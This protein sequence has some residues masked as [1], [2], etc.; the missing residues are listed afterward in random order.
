MEAE[1]VVPGGLDAQTSLERVQEVI[2][3]LQIAYI[4]QLSAQQPLEAAVPELSG[5]VFSF[6][7]WY[8]AAGAKAVC[9]LEDVASL[10]QPR[11]DLG[12]ASLGV[13]MHFFESY[14]AVKVLW[15]S[16]P[17]QRLFLPIIFHRGDSR[18]HGKA[19]T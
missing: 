7:T 16:C 6:K 4:A 17:T 14:A 3:V 11:F 1:L 10:L 19:G 12:D 13:L 8:E 2:D 18:R 5:F 15:P 9:W